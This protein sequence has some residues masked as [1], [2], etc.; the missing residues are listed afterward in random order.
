MKVFSRKLVLC[1]ALPALWL[2]VSVASFITCPL[3]LCSVGKIRNHIYVHR[4]YEMLFGPGFLD[5]GVENS[6]PNDMSASLQLEDVDSKHWNGGSTTAPHWN[7]SCVS[8]PDDGI[9]RTVLYS[10]SRNSFHRIETSYGRVNHVGSY[11]SIS[12][13][14]ILFVL[15]MPICSV[16]L[17]A[18]RR[19]RTATKLE[20]VSKPC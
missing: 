10:I 12:D 15:C 20:P 18:M 5:F 7:C 14:V 9:Y 17:C 11:F 19:R 13:W 16:Y 8:P 1:S 6:I 4:D 2:F 3:L